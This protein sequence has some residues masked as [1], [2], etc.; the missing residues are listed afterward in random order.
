MASLKFT[1]I[2][3]ISMWFFFL[4]FFSL[5]VSH[6]LGLFLSKW[7]KKWTMTS[8]MHREQ[9]LIMYQFLFNLLPKKERPWSLMMIFLLMI[10]INKTSKSSTILITKDYFCLLVL[11]HN[12]QLNKPNTAGFLLLQYVHLHFCLHLAVYEQHSHPHQNKLLPDCD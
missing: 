11:I 10:K 12:T 4:S 8:C 6:S 1:I 5:C 2:N 3:I 7:Q 9:K